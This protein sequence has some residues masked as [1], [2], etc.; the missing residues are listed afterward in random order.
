MKQKISIVMSCMM[1]IAALFGMT[2]CKKDWRTPSEEGDFICWLPPFGS[3]AG[4]MGLSEQGKMKE[5]I[6]IPEEI[7][8]KNVRDYTYENPWGEPEG[9]LE[10]ENLRELYII[11]QVS[12][13]KVDFNYSPNLEKVVFCYGIFYLDG[14]VSVKDNQRGVK[15]Y[16]AGS[17]RESAIVDEFGC[18]QNY[19][20]GKEETVKLHIANV[21]FILNF[22][23]TYD[24]D[25]YWVDNLNYG[26]KIG[27]IPEDP[28]RE[29]AA[30]FLGW[31]KEPEGINKWDFEK[32]T[33]PEP[34][35]N[36]EGKELYQETRLYGK[37]SYHL[38]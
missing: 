35:Y 12:M 8:G 14:V 26:E 38:Q 24:D 2:G 23:I 5:T 4:I 25:Y 9:N 20:L 28:N 36:E 11:P 13:Y 16:V 3:T 22:G 29:P 27:C 17:W 33:L 15:C 31:Y 18:I 7:A 34:I 30:D 32:D 1:G 6:I 10:S 37:W 19:V 21:S